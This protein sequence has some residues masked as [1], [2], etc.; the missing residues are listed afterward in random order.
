M[1][2][3]PAYPPSCDYDAMVEALQ[4]MLDAHPRAAFLDIEEQSIQLR[5]AQTPSPSVVNDNSPAVAPI[6][7]AE[8]LA[9]APATPSDVLE[10][11]DPMP[12]E[13]SSVSPQTSTEPHRL[14]ISSDN[15]EQDDADSGSL[16]VV[17]LHL[18][19]GDSDRHL[20][21]DQHVTTVTWNPYCKA[22]SSSDPMVCM[23]THFGVSMTILVLFL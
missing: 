14:Q 13:S 4:L 12:Q 2:K 7:I 18:G 3:N 5:I 6:L 23:G 20:S 10:N 17:R 9:D 16:I 8:E 11:D 21:S 1:L 19:H 22:V 15:S